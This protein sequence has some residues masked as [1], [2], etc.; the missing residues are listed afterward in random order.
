MCKI[1]R[2]AFGRIGSRSTNLG[3]HVSEEVPRQARA[4][5]RRV[6]VRRVD[7]RREPVLRNHAALQLPR[8]DAAARTG[9]VSLAGQGQIFMVYL[10]NPTDEMSYD[11]TCAVQH[12]FTTYLSDCVNSPLITPLGGKPVGLYLSPPPS[13]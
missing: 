8:H 13:F 3:R 2:I 1:G 6:L 7:V 5:G 9:R 4:R 11:R 12:E 10:H